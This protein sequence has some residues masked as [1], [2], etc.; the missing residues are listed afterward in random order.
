MTD[1]KNTKKLLRKEVR[2]KISALSPQYI[3]ESDAGIYRSVTAMSEFM[4]APTIFAYYSIDRE[5]DTQRLIALALE[6]GKTVALPI[7]MEEGKMEYAV[8]E[9]PED[10]LYKSKLRIPEPDKTARRITPQAGDLLLV[11]GLCFD[12]SGYRLG[13]GGGY[14][15]RYLTACPAF[16]LG[17]GRHQLL[18]EQVPAEIH[19]LPVLCL[20]TEKGIIKRYQMRDPSASCHKC[21]ADGAACHGKDRCHSCDCT[22]S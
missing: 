19:D 6:L 7:A 9:T 4:S 11:P 2:S 14:Y 10:T 15:D 22:S 20:V 16:T 13:Q 17:L 18:M 3:V 5:V 12:F 21:G 1:I 8:L